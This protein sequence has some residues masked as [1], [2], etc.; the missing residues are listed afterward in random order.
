M[1][2]LVQ[3]KLTDLKLKM[4]SVKWSRNCTVDPY[5]NLDWRIRA[6]LQSFREKYLGSMDNVV[7]VFVDKSLESVLRRIGIQ[8]QVLFKLHAPTV[9]DDSP[10]TEL[11]IRK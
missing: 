5:I 6:A 11:N 8:S 9:N 3:F 4:S 1:K 2:V 7:V 10:L